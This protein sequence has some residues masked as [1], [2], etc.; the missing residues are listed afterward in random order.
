MRYDELDSAWEWIETITKY[1]KKEIPLSLYE[2]WG[3]E[4]KFWRKH[5]MAN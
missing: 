1:W 2:C 5:K 3:P 4:I